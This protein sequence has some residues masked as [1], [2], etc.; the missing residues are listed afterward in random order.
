[1]H[2]F[3][4]IPESVNREAVSVDSS[5]KLNIDSV[6]KIVPASRI[7]AVEPII[8]SIGSVFLYRAGSPVYLFDIVYKDILCKLIVSGPVFNCKSELTRVLDKIGVIRRSASA[9]EAVKHSVPAIFCVGTKGL[10]NG[11]RVG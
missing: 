9:F 7:V 5:L 2:I 6:G 10:Q 4:G 8:G 3:R 1:M 11:I